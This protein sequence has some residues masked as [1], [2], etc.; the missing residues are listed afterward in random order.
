M[1]RLLLL[2]LALAVVTACGGGGGG[3]GGGPTTPPP[4]PPPGITFTSDGTAGSNSIALASGAGSDANTLILT[5]A[6]NSV[7]DLY[8][9]AF[10][11]RYP[12]NL[13]RYEGS[14]VADFLNTGGTQVSFNVVEPTPGTLVVGYSRLGSV[15]G[16]TGSGTLVTLRFTAT[17][18]GSGTFAFDDHT[19]FNSHGEP[20]SGLTWVAGR[21]QVVR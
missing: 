17:T 1:R 15:P 11:L 21:V 5:V 12:N 16:A 6:A 14:P 20:I 19:A 8:G 13:F 10:D 18:A 4:P 9:V 3:G 2:L 7:T